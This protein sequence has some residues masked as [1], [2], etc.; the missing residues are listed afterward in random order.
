VRRRALRATLGFLRARTVFFDNAVVPKEYLIGVE[1]QGWVQT[2]TVGLPGGLDQGPHV[3][4]FQ[5]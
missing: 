3:V 2:R 5:Q 1:N 4:A